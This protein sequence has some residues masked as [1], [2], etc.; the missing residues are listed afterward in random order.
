MKK[1]MGLV[2]LLL[3]LALLLCACG[4]PSVKFYEITGEN[5]WAVFPMNKAPVKTVRAG[6]KWFSLTGRYL[7]DSFSL[8]VSEDYNGLNEVYSVS[9]VDIW[10]FEAQGDFAVWSEE[11][12]E[13][14]RF[15][16]YNAEGGEAKEIFSVSA[17]A[18]FSP[19]NVGIY[20]GNVYFE[21]IDY[22]AKSAAVMR[23]ELE[24]GELTRFYELEYLGEY[25]CTSLSVDGGEL[26]TS[27]GKAGNAKLIKINLD[28]G[29]HESFAL[30]PS[31]SVVYACAHD[32]AQ[33]GLAL[34]YRD[35]DGNEHIGMVNTKNGKIKNVFTFEK[36]VYAY[37]DTLEFYGG[38]LYWVNQV[39][40]SGN[41][42]DHYRF[43]DY[44]CGSDTADEYLRTF[45]FSVYEGGIVLLSFNTVAYDAIYLTEIDFGGQ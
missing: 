19:A 23:Y 37:H 29:A 44:D 5:A 32:T 22:A 33:G 35:K 42:A 40:A 3:A 1:I 14:L 17:A 39:N 31:V 21:Y 30:S 10:F 38:H 34:Y 9:G 15:M 8:S 25:S 16:V 28:S 20:D 11:S 24:T 2:S 26:L 18:G 43:V 36:N 27:V 41:V 4:E 13:K 45:S 7:H 6:G 12:A